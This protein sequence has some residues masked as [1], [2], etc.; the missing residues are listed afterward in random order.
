MTSQTTASAPSGCPS[1]SQDRFTKTRSDHSTE[2]AA[3]YAELI[4]DLQRQHG[5][6]RIV[7]MAE[8][9]G[10]SHVTV[11]G[12]LQ[13]LVR[14]G[15]VV[16]RRYRGVFLTDTGKRLASDARERHATVREVLIALGAPSRAADRDAEGMEHHVSPE[17]LS[18]FRAFLLHRYPQGGEPS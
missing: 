1:V 18:A 3:D 12:T 14:D 5:E 2:L 16:R 10:T 8:H 7:D 4:D 17:T 9:L 11:V 13:R 15:I 6:A